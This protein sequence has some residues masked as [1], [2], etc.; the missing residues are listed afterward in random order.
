MG[1]NAIGCP[2]CR[3]QEIDSDLL[4]LDCVLGRLLDCLPEGGD[5]GVLIGRCED[6]LYEE[7]VAAFGVEGWFF[8][9]G[10]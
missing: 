6:G 5:V 9:H 7:L 3:R 8:F 1:G 2:S 10:L 4:L